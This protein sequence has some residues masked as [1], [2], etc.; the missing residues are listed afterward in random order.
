VGNNVSVLFFT[1][2]FSPLGDPQK[3]HS[4]ATTHMKDFG[5][6]SAPKSPDFQEF[7]SEIA[8]IRQ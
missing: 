4:S 1:N 3:Q 5:G 6:K 8:I 2:E 7:I